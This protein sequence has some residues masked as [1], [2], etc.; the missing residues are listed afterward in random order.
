MADTIF[1]WLLFDLKIKKQESAE[2]DVIMAMRK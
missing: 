2:N 1:L